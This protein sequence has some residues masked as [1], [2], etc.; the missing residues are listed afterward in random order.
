MQES[1]LAGRAPDERPQPRQQFRQVEGLDQV[2]IGARVQP[3]HAVSHSIA[4]REHQ[5]RRLLGLAQPAQ[6]FPTVNLRVGA[7]AESG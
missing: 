3:P 1:G 5:D 2:I 4:R 6:Q 7:L